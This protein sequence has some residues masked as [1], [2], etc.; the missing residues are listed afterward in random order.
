MPHQSDND[1]QRVKQL[2]AGQFAQSPFSS[3]LDDPSTLL[4][5]QGKMLRSRMLIRLGRANA[6]A[7]ETIL[8]SAAA[9]ELIHTA[10]LLHD[11]VIDNG[12]IRRSA[13]SYWEKHGA[14]GAILLGD[15]LVFYALKLLIPLNNQRLA[16][17][18]I[19]Y[20]GEVGEAEVLQE[21]IHRGE[22][23]NW[24]DCV[25]TARRKT[26]PLFAFMGFA[27]AGDDEPLAAILS[28]CGY[29]VGAAYQLADDLLDAYG[30]SE[31]TDKTLG[32]DLLR[33]KNTSAQFAETE[34]KNPAQYIDEL[35]GRS[36]QLLHAYP[37]IQTAWRTYLNDDLLPAIRKHT[38][39]APQ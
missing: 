36:I 22:P 14:S 25:Q 31:N 6:I 24:T 18:L 39:H 28:E 17:A 30:D 15:L 38:Q 27:A 5:N 4:T 9:T 37:A 19:H 12:H 1:I 2:M 16:E 21:I 26:G 10:S 33:S 32:R 13:P 35:C 7:E 8:R 29:L 23:Q 34:G 20:L 11:D 3:L